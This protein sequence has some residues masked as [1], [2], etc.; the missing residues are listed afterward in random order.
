[1]SF[2]IEVPGEAVPL[3]QRDLFRALQAATSNDHTQR[4]AASQQLT[5]WE[6]HHD[7]F[8]SL[9]VRW[10]E[11]IYHDCRTDQVTS[12]QTVFLDKTVPR[13]LR[14]LAVIQFKNGIDKYWRIGSGKNSIQPAEK[15]LIRSRLLQGSVD[16]D[17]RILALHNALATAKIVRIDYPADWPDAITSIVEVLQQVGQGN[18]AHLNGALL[19]LLR[20]VKEL[21]TA[22][23]RRS[24]TALKSVA[25][26][27]L[28]LLAEIYA[29]RTEAWVAFLTKG[30]GDEDDA[31]YAMQNSLL[32]LKILR[33]LLI[34]GFDFPHQNDLNKDFW[35]VSQ[36]HFGQF[37]EYV[38]HDS[39]IPAP[40][41]DVVGKFLLQFTKI[42][43]EMSQSHPASFAVLPNSIPLVHAYWDLVARFADVFDK[44]GGIRQ[45]PSGE[46]GTKS[47]VEGPLLERLALKGL[48]LL[49]ACIA[50]VF[51]PQQSFKYR[52]RDAKQMEEEAVQI[53]K[54]QLLTNEFVPQVVNVVVTKLFLFR[55]SDLEAWEESPEE[56]EAQEQTLGDAWMWQVRPCAERV[57]VD[58]LI[59]YKELLGPPLL[60]YFQT[61]MAAD[62][63]ILTK[64][65]VYTAMG[66][67][68]NTVYEVF[69][70][71]SFLAS[72]LVKDAQ[73]QAPLAKLLRR[74]IAILLS[75][76]VPV[77]ISDA[78]RPLVFDIF[79]H[80]MNQ[81][82]PIND[83]VVRI[84]AARQLK[85]IA[86]E[87]EFRA[88]FFLPYAT[89]IFTQL[90]GLLKSV[91]VDETKLA[92]LETLRS[93]VNRMDTQVSQ[94]GDQIM[95]T[96]PALWEWA[97]PEAYML[98]QAILSIISTLV[99]SM[100]LESQRY[101]GVML[102]LIAEA[103]DP[104]SQVHQFL[105]EEAVEVWKAVMTM[106]DPPLSNDLIK[107]EAFALPLL[108]FESVA[109]HALDIVK[110]YIV[111]APQAML[112]EQFR[113]PTLTALEQA[114]AA[115]DRSHAHFA[116]KSIQYL[117]RAAQ[118][119]GGSEGLAVIAS[120]MAA[121]NFLTKLLEGIHGAWEAHQTSGPK[122][123]TSPLNSVQEANCF[124]L[125]AR[126][127]VADPELFVKML[128]SAGDL[129][130]VWA[131]FSQEWFGS[132]DFMA[133]VERQKLSCLAL[134][135]LLELPQPMQ[136]LALGKL[137]DY[138][139]MWTL[140]IADVQEGDA[141][142][143]DCLVWQGPPS[144]EFDT[145]QD[146][147]ENI[148]TAK[149]PIHTEHTF[150]FVKLRLED[151]IRRA[152]GEQAFETNWAVNVD[153]EV[154]KGFQR[155]SLP[156]EAREGQ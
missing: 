121:T 58:L 154:L 150:S 98:K 72:T 14:F 13:D 135:R 63:D 100:R 28:Q 75:Q 147:R 20:V 77:K 8:P 16:E 66:S 48:L 116:A 44:S 104:S 148:F 12:A 78:S 2:A 143:V 45:A 49:K 38:S 137:Q 5:E 126:F 149:D 50:M 34:S 54:T 26:D 103:M 21:A 134:T 22:K 24:Q 79:R 81:G 112:G 67:A 27:T 61:A 25:P 86:D 96:L 83:E 46:V 97:G 65:A 29:T 19:L 47:K 113:R 85:P 107:L 1:M 151:V 145:P 125:L 40:Y 59:H 106:S 42:H 64:E 4:Q 146:T 57:F 152:G 33:R 111:L 3:N 120:D 139:S 70:F 60:S 55:K 109:D 9:Q 129:A 39:L 132:L 88:E 68:V 99:T 140:V 153:Q 71:D 93:F 74:R 123:R 119:F 117:I 53:I 51:Y 131:W 15:H 35:G 92:I 90:I 17:D 95:T 56:W 141:N 84:T 122:K 130:G 110:S 82:D 124:S 138:F 7:Y 73:L 105:L 11:C 136:D 128:S 23:L 144:S 102:P 52:S 41:Q 89:D 133:D 31:D 101:Q 10:P 80:L 36:S 32:S 69:D 76:W 155:L 91:E 87:F 30:Q 127:A 37:L 62:A 118:E 114:M 18:Q 156:K 115:K 43:I 108:E 6:S 142:G 94:F